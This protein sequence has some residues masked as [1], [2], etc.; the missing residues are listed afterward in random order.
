MNNKNDHGE[1][2]G[3]EGRRGEGAS[4]FL[5]LLDNWVVSSLLLCDNSRAAAS[6][7][8]DPSERCSQERCPAAC[9]TTQRDR[10]QL[11]PVLPGLGRGNSSSIRDTDT[12]C[13]LPA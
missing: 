8:R 6:L 10:A 3:V 11:C 13:A 4:L 2:G 1:G 7:S 9:A 5:S 12:C